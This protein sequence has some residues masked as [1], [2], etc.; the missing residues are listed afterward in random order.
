[1]NLFELLFGMPV[2]TI[3]AAE[4][5]DRLKNGKRPLVI[6]VRQPDEYRTGHIAGA[7]L[8]PLNQL[9]KRMKDLPQNREIVCV[10]A[11]GNRSGSAT[12]ILANAGLNAVNMKGG[13]NSWRHAG[14]PVKKGDTA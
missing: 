9:S 13:M 14:F 2:S 3:G 6:D 10:C 7:R 12:R 5:N 1:M 11:S 4:L 8:I